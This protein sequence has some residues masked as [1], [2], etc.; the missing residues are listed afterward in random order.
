MKWKLLQL[1]NA[2]WEYADCGEN[3]LILQYKEPV[4]DPLLLIHST[5]RAIEENDE[6]DL[7]D[8]V[9]G[10]NSI[11]LFYNGSKTSSDTIL[12]KIKAIPERSFSWNYRPQAH[13]IPVCYEKGL[14]LEE[15]SQQVNL[16]PDEIVARHAAVK[17]TVAMMGFLPGF[18]YLSGLPEVLHCP[19]KTSPRT[20]I[21]SG[22]VGIGGNQTGIYSFPSPG[23][24]QIIGQTPLRFF[25]PAH[26]PP[27]KIQ[28]GDFVQFEPISL[29][30]Y[31]HFPI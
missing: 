24:W 23:G 22:S 25:D 7:L 6:I 4:E 1:N 14:D 28:P 26:I 12:Q 21:P 31:D 13:K 2:N 17:Y 15:I 29:S 11:T 9:I 16:T 3:S 18:V 19:R 10:Y 20:K 8:V 27:T 30:S 5:S